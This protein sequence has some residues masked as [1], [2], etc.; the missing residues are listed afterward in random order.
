[1]PL[2]G[3]LKLAPLAI[4][5]AN[6]DAALSRSQDFPN[7]P[8]VPMDSSAIFQRIGICVMSAASCADTL[9]KG[10][11]IEKTWG[12]DTASDACFS[13]FTAKVVNSTNIPVEMRSVLSRTQIRDL[14]QER[15]N[16]VFNR[17]FRREVWFANSQGTTFSYFT[18]PF[19]VESTISW[20]MEVFERPILVG[21]R[22]I[23]PLDLNSWVLRQH[24]MNELQESDLLNQLSPVVDL[25]FSSRFFTEASPSQRDQSHVL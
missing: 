1:M 5:A 23:C 19:Y 8:A 16:P 17:L 4:F 24:V 20:G 22:D 3:F 7:F 15:L 2:S 6:I 14:I 25:F 9:E 11:Q 13:R 12:W 10:I 18:R 21:Q